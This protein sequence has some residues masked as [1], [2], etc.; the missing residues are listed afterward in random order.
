MAYTTRERDNGIFGRGGVGREEVLDVRAQRARRRE[1]EDIVL[2]GC[3]SGIVGEV[4]DDEAGAVG[5]E[6][7][8]ELG[9]GGN[10]GGR[11][12]CGCGEGEKNVALCVDKLDD[13]GGA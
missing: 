10:D 5:G 12:G 11:G 13:V 4:V 7:D 2:V 3:G 9:E 6:G 8:V 1:E